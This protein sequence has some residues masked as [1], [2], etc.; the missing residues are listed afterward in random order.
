MDASKEVSAKKTKRQKKFLLILPWVLLIAS[1]AGLLV[2]IITNKASDN[3]RV[4]DE[5]M[6]K[7]FVELRWAFARKDD[8]SQQSFKDFINQIA[9][10]SGYKSDPT[11]VYMELKYL[12]DTKEYDA[13]YF[14]A[15]ELEK[16]YSVGKIVDSRHMSTDSIEQLR[17]DISY[18]KAIKI[19]AGAKDEPGPDPEE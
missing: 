2:Y 5:A 9:T 10:K 14:K 8:S 6:A 12:Y 17:R 7:Q 3:Y 13:A 11:C 15:D 4:C 16:L 19:E 18:F 1:A